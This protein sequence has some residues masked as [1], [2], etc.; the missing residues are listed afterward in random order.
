MSAQRSEQPV[1]VISGGSSGIGLAC[2]RQLRKRGFRV[3]LLGRDEARLCSA[4]R[5]LHDGA[6]P[7]AEIYSLD[8]VDSAACE[9]AVAAI[10]ARHGRIDW[11]VTS[12]G[13]VEP[14][15]FMDLD[16]AAHRA[17]METNYFGTLHLVRAIVPAMRARA[18][19]RITLVASGAAFT[20]IV[21]YS[22]YSP[23]K[24]AVRALAETL[25]SELAPFG[26]S[27]SVACPPDT[28]TPQLAYESSRRPAATRLIARGGGELTAEQ[29]AKSMIGQA[30]AGR[31]VL[32]PSRLM[33]LFGLFHSL[34]AP[35]FLRRQR[36]L[37]RRLQAEDRA[38]TE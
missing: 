12:A 38:Q 4:E 19:G 34:Y 8:V 18:E 21:G 7:A 13:I 30:E 26:I 32:V 37:L 31:F 17:Q 27:V 29:V 23:G 14:G 20:G 6:F 15:L 35:F 25:F 3:V 22:G 1:A 36:R 11:L 16:L 24:F 10:L 33:A 2:A 28:D 5:D 9:V